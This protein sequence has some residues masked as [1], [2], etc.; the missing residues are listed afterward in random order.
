ME[1]F[2]LG[3][4]IFGLKILVALIIFFI[5]QKFSNIFVEYSIKA[6]KKSGIDETL[7]K[8]MRSVLYG[9][10]IV[11]VVLIAL[12]QLGIETTSIAAML[13]AVG[14]AIGLAFKDSLANISAGIMIIVFKPLKVGEF[15][16]A[17]GASGTV[18]EINIFN[19]ILKTGDNKIII[20]SNSSVI[21]ANIVNYSR[22]ETRRVDF[23]FLINY[24]NDL[25]LAKSILIQ[26]CQ[27]D[28]RIMKEPAIFVGV[29]NLSEVGINLTFRVWTRSENYWDVFHS[30]NE[31]I[32]ENFEQNRIFFAQNHIGLQSP[33]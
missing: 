32:K 8:F 30:L 22:N 12:S 13:G 4:G 5:G 25:R 16:D 33:K 11:V 21:S 6:L 3:A 19:T 29:G 14:L 23:S 10:F 24:D 28:D 26:I 27:D 18:E 7:E 17:G 9:V 31:K 15:V 1:N 2:I 20:I